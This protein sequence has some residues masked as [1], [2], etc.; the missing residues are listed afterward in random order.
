MNK[1]GRWINRNFPDVKGSIWVDLYSLV[2]LIRFGMGKPVDAAT[3]GVVLG[4]Y[5]I[6]KGMNS[7]P[8]A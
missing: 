2:A 7:T 3:L 4:A 6:H 5:V 8:D 1:I